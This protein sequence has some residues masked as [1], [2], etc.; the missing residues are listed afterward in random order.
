MIYRLVKN[1]DELHLLLATGEIKTITKAE[2]SHYVFHFDSINFSVSNNPEIEKLLNQYEGEVIA[3]LDNNYNLII[4]NISFLRELV[5]EEFPYYYSPS[6]FADKI[7]R[8]HG[9]VLRW[10]R[11]HRLP[12]AFQKGTYWYIPKDAPYPEDRR[13]G[14]DMSKRDY[15]KKT[16]SETNENS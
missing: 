6:E 12:G 1:N 9:I 5:P 16:S 7:N 2:A 14:R 15:K 3:T 10:C 11:E 13:A 8:S 4:H